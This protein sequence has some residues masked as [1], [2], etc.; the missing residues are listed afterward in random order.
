MQGSVACGAA[1]STYAHTA[2]RLCLRRA[3][4]LSTAVIFAFCCITENI[5]KYIKENKK[6]CEK[7]S[8]PLTPLQGVGCFVSYY[9]ILYL[10]VLHVTPAQPVTHSH[11]FEFTH[12][13]FPLHM[14][15]VVLTHALTVTVD[16]C[17]LELVS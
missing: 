9:R 4:A 8:N 6:P 12:R 7:I 3:G 10:R 11:V 17:R 1:P 13:P 14:P 2:R 16:T 5:N 15:P